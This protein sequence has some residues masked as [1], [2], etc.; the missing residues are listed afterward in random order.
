[1]GDTGLSGFARSHAR[2]ASHMASLLGFRLS[3]VRSEP[4]LDMTSEAF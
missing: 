4:G 3:T 1:M 2:E